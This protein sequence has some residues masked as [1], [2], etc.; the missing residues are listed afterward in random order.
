MY[1]RIKIK[2]DNLIPLC[3]DVILLLF[4]FLKRKELLILRLVSLEFKLSVDIF[5][6]IPFRMNFKQKYNTVKCGNCHRLGDKGLFEGPCYVCDKF[7]CIKCL[8]LKLMLFF[9]CIKARSCYCGNEIDKN[10]LCGTCCYNSGAPVSYSCSMDCRR[11]FLTLKNIQD[12]L[13]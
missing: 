13:K 10:F 5:F 3:Q 1:K 2:S 9:T 12:A 11:S 6:D 8:N 7:Y 4:E